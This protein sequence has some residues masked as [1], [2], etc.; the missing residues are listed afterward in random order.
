MAFN[1]ILGGFGFDGIVLAA[2]NG[3]LE[4]HP[5][6]STEMTRLFMNTYQ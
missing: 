1:D 6:S 3:V 2:G 5:F 4:I